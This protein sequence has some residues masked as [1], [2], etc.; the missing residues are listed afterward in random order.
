VPTTAKL[1]LPY[2][3]L[4]D[5]PNGPLAIQNL[6][7]AVDALD[8]LGGKRRVS[9]SSAIT[10]IESIVVDT[11]TLSLAANSS[12]QIDFYVCF[13]T[14]VAASDILM[15]IRLTSVSGTILGQT[16]ALGVYSTVP[17]YGFL[18]VQYKTTAAELDYF[19][20]TVV[21]QIG[22]GNITAIVPTSIIVKNQ[23]P[24]SLVGD[25]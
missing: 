22:T 6:A 25:F 20:G 19:C 23:G 7:N 21:R 11:Q 5:T 8:V 9:T 12:Y 15:K 4:S 1:G 17:N 3:S 14:S 2:P 16:A 10:T 24:A 18:S 13:N